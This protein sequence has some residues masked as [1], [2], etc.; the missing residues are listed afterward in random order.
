MGTRKVEDRFGQDLVEPLLRRVLLAIV[1]A[2]VLIAVVSAVLGITRILFSSLI[3]AATAGIMLVL[4]RRG[5]VLAA[6]LAVS[7]VLALSTIYTLVSGYGLLDVGVLALPSL[8]L[9]TSVLLSSRWT[10]AVVVTTNLTVLS[11]GLSERW[12]WLVT[13]NSAF[14]GYDDIFDAVILL[15]TTAAF[16][17]YLVSTLRRSI[18]QARVAQARTRDI[19]DATSD[20]IVIHDANDG[21]IVEVNETTLLMFGCSRSDLLAY[22][23]GSLDHERSFDYV[24]QA[25]DYVRRAVTDGSQSFESSARDKEGHTFWLEAILRAANIGNERCVVAVLRDITARR[26][27]EQRVR[28]AETF[29]AVGQL[30]GG[31]AHDFNNQLVGILGNAEFMIEVAGNPAEVRACAESILTSGR[32]AADLTRQLLAFARRGRHHNLPVNLHQLLGEVVALACRSIDKRI[33]LEQQLDA[34]CAVTVGDASAL[35]NALLNL[36]L[37]A[38]DAMP[39]GGT[40]RFVTRNVNLP[41][42]GDR[43]SGS[44]LAPGKYVEISVTDTGSGIEPNIMSKVFEPFFTTKSSG[45]GMGLAAVQGTVLEHQG[46]VEVESEVGRGSTFRLFLPVGSEAKVLEPTVSSLRPLQQNRGRILVVDDEAAVAST[47]KRALKR[48]GYDV[49]SCSGGQAAL[50][51]YQPHTFDLVL[52]DMMMPDLDGVEVLRRLRSSDATA[53]VVIMTGHAPESI[54]TRLLEFPDVTVL[55]KPFLPNELLKKVREILGQAE[56][57]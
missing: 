35:Q 25:V 49:N 17:Q 44:G 38:R 34:E 40:V 1:V 3:N 13:P 33:V 31:I 39:S 53:R 5:C 2:A 56:P 21:R 47:I 18:V 9:L 19:L 55:S 36:L 43:D 41:H 23:P 37:N 11:V 27:L 30:A 10:L 16:V 29:R 14:V 46:T 50:A 24:D 20:A 54:Q 12:G 32:R 48:G 4:V 15:T 28:E 6:S 22:T 7:L 42:H 52:L 45:T 51:V 8:F 57:N 26:R